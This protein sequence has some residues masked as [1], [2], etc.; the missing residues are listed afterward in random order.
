M[1]GQR[2]LNR[3][4]ASPSP[5]VIGQGKMVVHIGETC[6]AFTNVEDYFGCVRC[7]FYLGY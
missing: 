5:Q 4:P 1:Y 6:V 3:A 2:E 7:V